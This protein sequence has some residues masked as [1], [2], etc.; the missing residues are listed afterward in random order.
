MGGGRRPALTV[1]IPVYRG[2]RHL[3][4]LLSRLEGWER[5]DVEVVVVDDCSGDETAPR[6]RDAFPDVRLVYRGANG[7]FAAA[8]NSGLRIARGHTIA[9][10]NSDF[11]ISLPGLLDLSRRARRDPNTILGPR[12][13]DV[14]GRVLPTTHRYFARPGAWLAEYFLPFLVLPESTRN[15]LLGSCSVASIAQSETAVGWLTGS[16]L[17][18]SRSVLRELGDLDERFFMN[19]EEK[20]WQKRAMAKGIARVY[21]PTVHAIHDVGHGRTN[22]IDSQTRRFIWGWESRYRYVQK[23]YGDRA[24][25]A[26]RVGQWGAFL[27]SIPAWVGLMACASICGWPL[28][29]GDATKFLSRYWRGLYAR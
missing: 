18:F 25:L 3:R 22:L 29:L 16:C 5:V 28:K 26:L 12:T 19:S 20:D 2:W 10:V 11:V 15:W 14:S 1:V 7:G 27:A 24:V 4:I 6:I 17:V 13:L 8:V 9:I 21:V 23:W